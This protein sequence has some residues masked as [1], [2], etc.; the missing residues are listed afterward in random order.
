MAATAS[1]TVS[2]SVT[3][4]A[5]GSTTI[6]PIV[7]SSAAAV[8][9]VVD[10]VLQLGA[11][12]FIPPAGATGVLITLPITNTNIVTLKGVTADTG[13]AIGKTT[14]QFLS[15]DPTAVPANICL[16]SAATQTGLNTQLSFF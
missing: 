8:G 2:G 6:G 11:N 12:N 1:V 15:W 10:V 14:T 16:T 7:I 3:G 9:Q 13:I 5:R 4:Q